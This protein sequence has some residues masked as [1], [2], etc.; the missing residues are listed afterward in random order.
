LARES[1]RAGNEKCRGTGDAT[2]KGGKTGLGGRERNI[3]RIR[4]HQWG[5]RVKKGNEVRGATGNTRSYEGIG[6]EENSV[7]SSKGVTERIR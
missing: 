2:R 1:T 5:K 6:S 4:Y 3:E 7:E